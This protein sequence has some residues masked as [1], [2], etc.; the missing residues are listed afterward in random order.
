[1][2]MVK[3]NVV[4]RSAAFR[5]PHDRI[6]QVNQSC[7][8]VESQADAPGQRPVPGRC[9]ES[10]RDHDHSDHGRRIRREEGDRRSGAL[11]EDAAAEH[12]ATDAPSAEKLEA[13][14]A[15]AERAALAVES[16][17]EQAATRLEREKFEVA[18]RRSERDKFL[19]A[20]Y[21]RRQRKSKSGAWDS[22]RPNAN[23]LT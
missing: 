14:L 3:L 19:D 20:G 23:S 6:C 13:D 15:T 16:D 11:P 21:C 1:M 17:V 12:D 10:G 7:R 5:D 22:I 8:K 9:R 18:F 4:S 2:F